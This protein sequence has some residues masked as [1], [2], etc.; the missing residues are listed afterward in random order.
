MFLFGNRDTI[1]TLVVSE[2]QGIKGNEKADKLAK[3][4]ATMPFIGPDP[5]CGCK[6]VT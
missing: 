3:A 2:S 5:C 1:T 4:A 6:I